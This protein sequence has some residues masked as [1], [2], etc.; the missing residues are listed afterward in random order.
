MELSDYLSNY[1]KNILLIVINVLRRR[2]DVNPGRKERRNESLI[3]T[4]LMQL[5]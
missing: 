2:A 3:K 4:I 5:N 1:H